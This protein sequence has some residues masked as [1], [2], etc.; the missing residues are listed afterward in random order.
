MIVACIAL[1]M[2]RETLRWLRLRGVLTP[3]KHYRCWGCT[4]CRW[5]LQWHLQSVEA[6]I[7]GWSR[8]MASWMLA[9]ASS[10]VLP[11]EC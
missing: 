2:S 8:L 6:T 11:L 1:G 9:S 5:L 10:R 3:C 4:Q 7:K